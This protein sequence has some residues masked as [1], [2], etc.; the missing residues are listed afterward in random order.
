MIEPEDLAEARG[1]VPWS[2]CWRECVESARY[3][4]EEQKDEQ[5]IAWAEAWLA[6][7]GG[8]STPPAPKGEPQMAQSNRDL[9]QQ[10]LAEAMYLAWH[11]S[12]SAPFSD[13]A[14][15]VCADYLN[16]AAAILDTP[17]VEVEEQWLVTGDPGQGYP[18]YDFTWSSAR[19]D[20]PEFAARSF[21]DVIRCRGG[22]PDGPHLACRTV[23]TT[24]WSPVEPVKEEK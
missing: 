13:R 20:D 11:G 15:D 2:D 7:K 24:P 16:A 17:G 9:A 23:I 18:P 19:Y 3:T 22:W 1:C 12:G 14:E 8:W 21:V 4:I 10:W 5:E 6:Q